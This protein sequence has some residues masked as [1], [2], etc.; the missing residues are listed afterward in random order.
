MVFPR[1]VLADVPWRK[2]AASFREDAGD[3]PPG[4]FEGDPDSSL[5]DIY[6]RFRDAFKRSSMELM[7]QP[8]AA[9]ILQMRSC[10]SFWE[11]QDKE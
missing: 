8:Y 9:N 11:R 3:I 10:N 2:L 4:F 6:L 1:P 5:P 7:A